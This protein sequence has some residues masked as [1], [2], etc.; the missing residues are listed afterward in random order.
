MGTCHL[1]WEHQ[2]N[3]EGSDE[4]GGQDDSDPVDG[5]LDAVAVGL[6]RDPEQRVGG[7]YRHH[8]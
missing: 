3:E 5:E 6:R 1:Q 7:D 2:R 4:R 8:H